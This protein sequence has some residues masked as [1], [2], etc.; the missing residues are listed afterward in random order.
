MRLSP[1]QPYCR[2]IL[3]SSDKSL[4]CKCIDHTSLS[5]LAIAHG[6]EH[7]GVVGINRNNSLNSLRNELRNGRPSALPQGLPSFKTNDI[8]NSLQVRLQDGLLIGL[9]HFLPNSLCNRSANS[10]LKSR[11]I[12]N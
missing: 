12:R 2:E 4:A 11:A 5:I 1:S 7:D 9:Q 8:F 10:P 6:A 3:S